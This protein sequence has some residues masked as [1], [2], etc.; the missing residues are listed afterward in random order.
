M[1]KL[2]AASFVTVATCALAPATMAQ[3]GTPAKTAVANGALAGITK[4]PVIAFLGI[5]YAAPPVGALRWQPPHPAAN[6]SGVRNA[7]NAGP[8]CPQILNPVG[9]RLP[10]TTEYLIP[11]AMSEDCLRLNVWR[12]K[13]AAKGLPVLF[14]I[15]GGG[16]VEGSNTVP[17]YDGAALAAKG[18][19]VVSINYRLG[20]LANLAHVELTREQDG[21]SGNYGFQDIVAALKW[22]NA[23]V[24]AFG[25]DPK[26]ITIAGQSAGAGYVAQLIGSPKAA[27]LFSRAITESGSTWARALPPSLAEGEAVGGAFGQ[28]ISAPTLAQLRALDANMLVKQAADFASAGRGRIVPIVDGRH[29]TV[30]GTRAQAR[31]G[32]NDTPILSGYNADEEAGTDNKYGSWTIAELAAKRTANFGPVAAE[33]AVVYPAATAAEAAEIG[34]VMARERSRGGMYEWARRRAAVSANPI[35]LYFFN[36]PHPG[37]TKA[38]YGTF[39]SSEIPYVFGTFAA[40]RPFTDADRTISRDFQARWVN[41]IKGGTPNAAGLAAWTA[42]DPQRPMTM[43]LGDNEEEQPILPPSSLKL[44]KDFFSATERAAAAR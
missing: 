33:A 17:V 11:G 41:F 2:I 12:P 37:P 27:G 24:S 6:W 10:W 13:S 30:D 36:H 3:S 39:H 7:D 35:Y 38:R 31:A 14:W 29:I 40:D 25:G 34:K 44:A 42:F 8:S 15:H 16:G 19:I 28:S 1:N 9:G 21:A 32:F 22:A 4:G 23:N 20:V 43:I 5:P 18:I 26:R